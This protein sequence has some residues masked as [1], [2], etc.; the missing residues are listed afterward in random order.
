M[1]LILDDL[2]DGSCS[3]YKVQTWGWGSVSHESRSLHTNFASTSF[4]PFS[5]A[6][7]ITYALCVCVCVCVLSLS[8]KIKYSGWQNMNNYR[9][10]AQSQSVIDFQ[11]KFPRANIGLLI[12]RIIF[13]FSMLQSSFVTQTTAATSAAA[14][15]HNTMDLI[16]HINTDIQRAHTHVRTDRQIRTHNAHTRTV[17]K[18]LWSPCRTFSIALLRE[19]SALSWS[20]FLEKKKMNW[21][22]DTFFVHVEIERYRTLWK[23]V[24]LRRNC[25]ADCVIACICWSYSHTSDPFICFADFLYTFSEYYLERQRFEGDGDPNLQLLN[26]QIGCS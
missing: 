21:A 7:L 26:P 4:R 11:T 13:T 18:P 16:A 15:V 10:Q 6:S 9:P 19:F 12:P 2:Y 22:L 20:S 23:S 14:P 17:T 5:I 3:H 8:K 25:L 24:P 1:F